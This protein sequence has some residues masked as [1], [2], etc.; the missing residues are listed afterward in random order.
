[1]LDCFGRIRTV[2]EQCFKLN[3]GYSQWPVSE[4]TIPRPRIKAL[5]VPV[6]GEGW[7]GY[8]DTDDDRSDPAYWSSYWNTSPGDGEV[9]LSANPLT[10]GQTVGELRELIAGAG[11]E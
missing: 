5:L 8:D 1:M 7:F 10:I 4:I 6:E 3:D 11:G 9:F 2:Q